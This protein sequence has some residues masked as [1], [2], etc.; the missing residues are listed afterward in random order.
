MPCMHEGYSVHVC[1]K[2]QKDLNKNKRTTT[3]QQGTQHFPTSFAIIL[4]M[5]CICCVHMNG[6]VEWIVLGV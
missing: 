6:R 1:V 2:S 3:H 5:L 4:S